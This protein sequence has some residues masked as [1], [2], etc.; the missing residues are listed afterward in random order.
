MRMEKQKSKQGTQAYRWIWAGLWIVGGLALGWYGGNVLVNA[1]ASLTWPEAEGTIV[2]CGIKN[3]AS[4][5]RPRSGS[6]FYTLNVQFQFQVDGHSSTGNRYR[7][8][9]M[10]SPSK[11]KFRHILETYSPGTEASVRYDP[12]EPTKSVLRAGPNLDTFLPVLGAFLLLGMGGWVAVVQNAPHSPSDRKSFI[13]GRVRS[14]YKCLLIFLFGLCISSLMIA[15]ASILLRF[16]LG[17]II[18]LLTALFALPVG[19]RIEG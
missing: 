6:V 19:K 8:G 11:R 4:N 1:F 7:W 2:R 10:G 16:I 15:T 18:L 5:S 9:F 17:P 12:D 13:S 14:I 3:V